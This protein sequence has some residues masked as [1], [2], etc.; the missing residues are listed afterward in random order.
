MPLLRRS[1]PPPWS[2][3]CR[4]RADHR[5][6]GDIQS[7]H[8]I[9]DA[10]IEPRKKT[11]P[12]VDTIAGAAVRL[13]DPDEELGIAE[14]VETA[15]AAREL[16]HVPVWAALTANGIRS[17]VPPAGL[18]RL[19]VYADNDSSFTGQAAAYDLARRL[20]GGGLTVEVH[21]PPITDTDWLDVLNERSR[22]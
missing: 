6:G 20:T 16:F 12:P 18:L 14:G 15:L 4:H 11:L 21:V 19:H 1:P 9:Y 10:N 8:R 7:A 13:D 3:P 5:S 17:F 2:L 22:W